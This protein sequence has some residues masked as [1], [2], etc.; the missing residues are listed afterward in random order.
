M[1]TL[2]SD[3]GDG[4]RTEGVYG[5]SS[6]VN[7]V[8]KELVD[9]TKLKSLWAPLTSDLVYSRSELPILSASLG[10]FPLEQQVRSFLEHTD[11]LLR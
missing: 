7:L 1:S 6:T 8:K 5:V 11:R 9:K 2:V 3:R 4:T 10:D